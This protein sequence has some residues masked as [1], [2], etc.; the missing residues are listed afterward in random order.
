MMKVQTGFTDGGMADV[1]YVHADSNVYLSFEFANESG[2]GV[3]ATFGANGDVDVDGH[4][5]G[6]ASAVGTDG[7]VIEVDVNQSGG[8]GSMT[9]DYFEATINHDMITNLGDIGITVDL[10]GS[11][12]MADVFTGSSKSDNDVLDAREAHSLE[13]DEGAN[14][15]IQVTGESEVTGS[16]GVIV[17]AEL[18]DVDFIMVRDASP[19]DDVDFYQDMSD[20]NGKQVISGLGDGATD[21]YGVGYDVVTSA[22]VDT[23]GSGS[24]MRVYYEGKHSDFVDTDDIVLGTE[25]VFDMSASKSDRGSNWEGEVLSQYGPGQ[26]P[27]FYIEVSGKKLA[28][29]FDEEKGANGEWKVDSSALKVAEGVDTITTPSDP[30]QFAS[31]VMA[32][33]G[34]KPAASVQQSTSEQGTSGGGF[35]VVKFSGS[36]GSGTIGHNGEKWVVDF[37]FGSYTVSN[38]EVNSIGEANTFIEAGHNIPLSSLTVTSTESASPVFN[39]SSWPSPADWGTYLSNNSGASGGSGSTAASQ[40]VNYSFSEDIYLNA[41]EEAI[42]ELLA[43]GTASDTSFNFGF[44]TKMDLETDTGTVTVNLKLQETVTSNVQTWLDNEAQA[45]NPIPVIAEAVTETSVNTYTGSE[46]STAGADVVNSASTSVTLYDASDL[47]NNG[48]NTSGSGLFEP[49]TTITLDAVATKDEILNYFAQDASGNHDGGFSGNAANYVPLWGIYFQPID[50]GNLTNGAYAQTVA[51]NAD[52]SLHSSVD[53]DEFN[54]RFQTGINRVRQSDNDDF[55]AHHTD[56]D[57]Q[58][59]NLLDNVTTDQSLIDTTAPITLRQQVLMQ[60]FVIDGSNGSTFASATQFLVNVEDDDSLTVQAVGTNNIISPIKVPI[61]GVSTDL[62]N[63]S[64]TTQTIPGANSP[65]KS[66]SEYVVT[67]DY[68]DG[69]MTAQEFVAG[70]TTGPVLSL[71]TAN[72][73][74][75]TANKQ[76]TQAAQAAVTQ[77]DIDAYMADAPD[78]SY[79]F[80]LNAS[81]IDVAVE[82]FYNV[83]DDDGAGVTSSSAAGEFVKIDNSADIALGNGGDDTYVVEAGVDTGIFG[84][85]ALEYGNIGVRGGLTGSIDA[86]NINSVDSVDDLTFRRG[87][88]RNEEDDNTL[89]IGDKIGTGEETV[90][91]D[92]YNEYLDF[93]RVEYLTV[94]DGANNNEIFEIVTD[95]NLSEWDNEIYV[96][97]NDGGSMTVELGGLDYVFGSAG[98]DSVMIDLDDLNGGEDGTI[99]LS[100]FGIGDT[101]TLDDKGE[102]S[103]ADETALGTALNSAMAGNDTIILS[104]DADETKLSL[105]IDQDDDGIVDITNE[106]MF[107]S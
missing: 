102:L 49:A 79:S 92:N 67:I 21:A 107:I 56:Y 81:D 22:Q 52:G 72:I 62:G 69:N 55:L 46:L 76:V 1:M 66:N 68:L 34:L 96:A 11:D 74:G 85:V 37:T 80:E 47:A 71:E 91:F 106:Y 15:Y 27:G 97:D 2:L 33:Y 60:D 39:G 87:E 3:E 50:E 73:S 12:G 18:K 7:E 51:L 58:L 31:D 20:L 100:G 90:L 88:F 36:S 30:D 54:F 99:N 40:G 82:S 89:F 103:Q 32:R 23:F 26:D 38:Y 4:I 25:G 43:T 16:K 19:A 63:L 13:F 48:F 70:V 78:P 65:L 45:G 28:V 8:A 59:Q 105:A 64:G 14:G 44:Y 10:G 95:H 86:V 6:S 53:P 94:E 93:R 98:A 77:Q 75:L 41:T 42:T 35:P 84:G 24:N 57:D 5:H 9:I 83:A 61:S 104:T 17:N 101:I 29:T